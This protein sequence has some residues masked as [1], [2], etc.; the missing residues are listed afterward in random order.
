MSSVEKVREMV[1]NGYYLF[2]ETPEL[3]VKRLGDEVVDVVYNSFKSYK[4]Q[5]WKTIA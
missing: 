1:A 5:S 3:Y 2:S 4:G